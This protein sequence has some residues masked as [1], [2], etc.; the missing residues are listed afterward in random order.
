LTLAFARPPD[1]FNAFNRG[2]LGLFHGQPRILTS[3]KPVLFHTM[4][5]AA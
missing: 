5:Y 1:S 2:P 4:K 3:P